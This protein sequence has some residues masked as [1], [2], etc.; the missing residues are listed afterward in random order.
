M[1]EKDRVPAPPGMAAYDEDAPLDDGYSQDENYGH[2]QEAFQ[3]RDLRKYAD[4]PPGEPL[5][6]REAEPLAEPK[7]PRRRH[8]GLG[9]G[10]AAGIPD[11]S[12][13]AHTG[14]GDPDRD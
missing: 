10:G 5:R 14:F 11:S 12:G 7:K 13:A 1:E 4:T 2:N 8:T 9:T 3:L 6:E